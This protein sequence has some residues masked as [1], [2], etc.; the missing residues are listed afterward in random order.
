MTKGAS[1]P[2]NFCLCSVIIS[3]DFSP[4]DAHLNL[5]SRSSRFEDET[6]SSQREDDRDRSRKPEPDFFL[7]SMSSLDDRSE[8]VFVAGNIRMLRL[9]T[10]DLCKVVSLKTT[11]I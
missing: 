3:N 11:I 2:G 8:T 7:S 5:M 4:L 10:T 1:R 9:E 6:E